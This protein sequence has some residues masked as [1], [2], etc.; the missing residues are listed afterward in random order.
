MLEDL[1]TI[2]SKT[3]NIKGKVVDPGT[4]FFEDLGADYLDMVE[5]GMGIE[6]KF[7]IEII[8]GRN[9]ENIKTVADMIQVIE[10]KRNRI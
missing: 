1:K 6:D 9:I 8:T 7:H 10:E 5:I 3:I 4:R 2:I